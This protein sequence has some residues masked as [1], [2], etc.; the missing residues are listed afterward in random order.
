MK[1]LFFDNPESTVIT[2]SRQPPSPGDLSLAPQTRR[3]LECEL[4]LVSECSH[5]FRELSLSFFRLGSAFQVMCGDQCHSSPGGNIRD[6]YRA[7]RFSDPQ[8]FLDT[9]SLRLARSCSPLS[10]FMPQW[11]SLLWPLT[12]W[13]QSL[14]FPFYLSKLFCFLLL[15]NGDE[16]IQTVMSAK[17]IC[18]LLINA[19]SFCVLYIYFFFQIFDMKENKLCSY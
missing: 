4:F 15:Q 1:I 11:L 12:S 18:A 2:A 17:F 16:I 8:H 5:S 7:D 19:H 13:K 9:L 6:S 10:S 14:P 3:K